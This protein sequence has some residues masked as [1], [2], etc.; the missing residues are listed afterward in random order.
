MP[1]EPQSN[2]RKIIEANTKG[3]L[4]INQSEFEVRA[5]LVAGDEPIVA[6][7]VNHRGGTSG[8]ER[9]SKCHS[10]EESGRI[11]A[12]A[13]VF[14][15][16]RRSRHWK[17]MSFSSNARRA[18]SIDHIS[19]FVFPILFGVFSISFFIWF[20]WCSP[21]KLDNWGY[22]EYNPDAKLED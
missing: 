3:D 1:L 14:A 17:D 4:N 5:P 12:A 2:G 22:L 10:P 13:S 15:W 6:R 18:R 16:L 20:A 19:K 7:G 8:A 9:G 21:A 11:K